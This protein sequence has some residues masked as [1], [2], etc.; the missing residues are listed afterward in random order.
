MH[1]LED[2][3]FEISKL[4][5]DDG[6][7]FLINYPDFNVC[8]SDGDTVEEAVV[9][10]RDAL[11]SAIQA[12]EEMAIPVPAPGSGGFSGKFVARVPESLYCARSQLTSIVIPAQAGI[13]EVQQAKWIPAYAGMTEQEVSLM[14]THS[15]HARLVAKA[16]QEHVSLNLLCWWQPCW[17]RASGAGAHR[18]DAHHQAG[19]LKLNTKWAMSR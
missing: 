3:P 10:G 14:P 6:G 19:L 9:N 11:T 8:F 5:E 17:Q 4:S 16:K 1:N 7:G 2:Y 18:L 13:Q 12:M 15:I